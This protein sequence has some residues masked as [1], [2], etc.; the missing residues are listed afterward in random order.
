[1]KSAALIILVALLSLTFTGIAST[2]PQ[3]SGHAIEPAHHFAVRASLSAKQDVVV[4]ITDCA[5][6]A[7]CGDAP[8]QSCQSCIVASDQF[9]PEPG[10]GLSGRSIIRLSQTGQ[11]SPGQILEPPRT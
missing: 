11:F 9:V 10:S 7:D 2:G 5:G 3:T 1:M 6:A 8:D 4:V